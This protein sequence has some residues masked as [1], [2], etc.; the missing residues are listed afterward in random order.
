MA[1]ETKVILTLLAEALVRTEN[2]RE[3]YGLLVC[4]ANAEG[5]QL[6]SYKD[7]RIRSHPP[8]S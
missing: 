8:Y 1:Y 3:A 7:A 6:P 5:L 2:V 4:A